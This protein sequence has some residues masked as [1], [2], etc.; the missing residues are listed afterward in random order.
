M[1]SGRVLQRSK[2]RFDSPM[3]RRIESRN[4]KSLFGPWA[5]CPCDRAP[6]ASGL[7]DQVWGFRSKPMTLEGCIPQDCCHPSRELSHRPLA[8]SC[9]NHRRSLPRMNH[10]EGLIAPTDHCPSKRDSHQL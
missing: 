10:G 4:E 6:P 8:R 1:W 5:C 9:E 7:I 2:N 3:D